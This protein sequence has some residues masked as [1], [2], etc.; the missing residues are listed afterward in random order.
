MS[1]AN[2]YN[3]I[4]FDYRNSIKQLSESA[5]NNM[6]EKA[7]KLGDYSPINILGVNITC[8]D[9]KDAVFSKLYNGLQRTNF[10]DIKAAM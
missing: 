5:F 2:I 9:T 3:Q 4:M 1:K 7:S 8:G 6:M 10:D